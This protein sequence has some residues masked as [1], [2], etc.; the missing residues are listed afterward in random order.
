MGAE[1]KKVEKRRLKR[2]E[3]GDLNAEKRGRWRNGAEKKVGEL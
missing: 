1:K 2:E 3:G